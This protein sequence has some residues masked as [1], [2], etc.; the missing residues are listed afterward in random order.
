MA[1]VSLQSSNF[2]DRVIR[3]FN[4]LGELHRKVDL[5]GDRDKADAT[6]DM[7][8]LG[9]NRVQFFAINFPSHVLRHQDFRIKLSELRFDISAPG[10]SHLETPEHRQTR[11]DSIFLRVPVDHGN[12]FQA[13]NVK[14]P[15][16]EFLGLGRNFFIRHRDFH[17]FLEEDENFGSTETDPFM[18]DTRF[19]II[20]PL[21]RESFPNVH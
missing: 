15:G 14:A 7:R 4:F 17:L 21:V 19:F 1:F 5:I 16:T 10:T 3:H 12:F 18:F 8:E 2:P 20:D 9:G 13:T 11:E 6:F